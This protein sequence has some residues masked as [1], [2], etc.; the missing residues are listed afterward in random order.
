MYIDPDIVLV[1]ELT[2]SVAGILGQYMHAA[3]LGS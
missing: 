1:A 2:K 3:A